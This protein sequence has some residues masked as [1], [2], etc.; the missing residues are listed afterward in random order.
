MITGEQSN[1][2]Y[3]PKVVY[4]N[5]ELD[6]AFPQKCTMDK[7]RVWVNDIPGFIS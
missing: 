7:N 6:E 4:R 2:R 1:D 5:V 3:G